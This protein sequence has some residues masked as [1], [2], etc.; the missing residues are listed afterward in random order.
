MFR[1]T[2]SFCMAALTLLMAASNARRAHAHFPWLT[3]DS[4]GRAILFFGESPEDRTYKLPEAVAKASV[5]CRTADGKRTE[6]ALQPVEEEQFIGRR[7]GEPMANGAALETTVEYGL[8]HSM[9]LTYYAKHLPGESVKWRQPGESD[10]LPL[11]LLPSDGK[12]GLTLT[13]MWKGQPR[14]GVSIMLTDA[15]AD[16]HEGETDAQGKVVFKDVPAGPVG[17]T[18]N[19]LDDAKGDFNGKKY[20]SAGHYATLTFDYKNPSAE[21]TAPTADAHSPSDAN[22]VAESDKPVSKYPPLP[23]PVSSFGGAVA[24]GYVYVYSGHTGIEHEHSRDNLSKRFLRLKLNGGQGWEELAMQTPLQGMPLVAHDG[25]LYRVGGLSARNPADE[26]E[27]L[28]SVDEFA[29]YDPETGRWTR[30]PSLP[31]P[32]SSHDAVVIGDKLCVVGGWR[33]SG[34]RNGQWLDTAWSFDLAKPQGQGKWEPLTS[35]PFRRRALAVGQWKGNLVA[36]GGITEDRDISRNVD[37]LDLKSGDWTKVADLPG[38]GMDGFGAS[39]WNQGERLFASGTQEEVFV[40][41]G[42]GSKWN[43]VAK[44]RQPRFFH[45]MLPGENGKLIAVAGASEEG[46]LADI[47][48]IAPELQRRPEQ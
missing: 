9:L 6:L 20:E 19:I 10:S 25:K 4:E 43:P 36:L 23:E 41:A 32:R 7:S 29:S 1:F 5:Y 24:D 38:N 13:A 18:A 26:E 40:L 2:T 3:T 15:K 30:L 39:I 35:P 34:S 14:E 12:G 11:E 27:D 46:H 21:A 42:D 45:R 44:M 16:Q 48:E 28:H 22:K 37:V 47:E 8:Y 33:L 17:V 31:E